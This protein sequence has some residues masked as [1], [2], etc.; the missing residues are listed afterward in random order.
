MFVVTIEG[1]HVDQVLGHALS[2]PMKNKNKNNVSSP[3]SGPVFSKDEFT[4]DFVLY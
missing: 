2:Y 3:T 1:C 4:T